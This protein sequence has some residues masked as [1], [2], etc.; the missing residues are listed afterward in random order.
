M[1]L[2][3][4]S[5]A[6]L[7]GSVMSA[8][9]AQQGHYNLR[10][11]ASVSPPAN[12]LCVNA[13]AIGTGPVVWSGTNVAA[14]TDGPATC[15]TTGTDVWYDWMAA[16]SG[17]TIASLCA[18][19]GGS[20]N[21]DTVMTIYN[22]A[23][24]SPLGSVVG[25]ND[26]SCGT[27]Q[28]EVTFCATAGDVY[29]IRIGGWNGATGNFSLSMVEV[30]PTTIDDCSLPGVAVT[31]TNPYDN[32]TATAQLCPAF[33]QSS[34]KCGTPIGR[35]LWYTW[36]AGCTSDV[37]V[38]TCGDTTV[39]TKIAVWAGANCP[40]GVAIAC[41]DDSCDGTLQSTLSF[42]A[43][44][45]AQYT[46]QIGSFGSAPGGPGDFTIACVLPDS[47][48]P[49]HD[50]DTENSVA[51]TGL[52][53]ETLWMHRQGV[54][55]R[56]T[57]VKSIS[58]AWGSALNTAA[59]NPTVGSP[60][61]V[62][63]WDDLDDDGNPTTNLGPTLQEISATVLTSGG[64][65]LDTYPLTPHVLVSGVYFIGASY[66][67]DTVASQFSAPLDGDQDSV[68]RAYIAGEVGGPLDFTSLSTATLPLAEIDSLGFPGVW[69][70]ECE[71][72][73]LDIEEICGTVLSSTNECPCNPLPP[74]TGLVGNGC[75]HSGNAGS[76]EGWQG[77]HLAGSGDAL[78]G[79]EDTVSVFA[80]NVRQG[81]GVISLFLQGDEVI[82]TI[83]SDGMICSRFNLKLWLWKDPV[84][85]GGG[86]T[87]QTGPGPNTIPPTTSISQ[88]S[89]D[90]GAPLLNGQT[91]VYTMIFRDPAP[92][93]GC[94][95]LSTVN[96]T[97][98]LRILW[99]QL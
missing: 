17:A 23:G 12:D 30:A 3:T 9:L 58:T 4:M 97:N 37:T 41:N 95:G 63:I 13:Q 19:N 2:I 5:A 92:P 81:N 6:V 40:A 67:Q 68:S 54:P 48:N 32:S 26:T 84:G 57:V 59:Q 75:P 91:K 14:N 94:L 96:T 7:I 31:G 99:S 52:G 93:Q 53:S 78:I 22:G 83:F 25:C 42:S 82:S 69:L 88:R 45:G 74:D 18:A 64:D 72:K 65:Q 90:L 47:C 55:G 28:S 89:S 79:G 33:G 8:A 77:A 20:G 87:S 21:F 29:K 49:Y 85:P 36:T 27:D 70:L 71:C 39:D 24:C 15:A 86:I 62:A 1:K 11:S 56:R 80:T 60:C 61:R 34:P 73:D 16:V 46:V 44:Q 98:G 10:I 35:D 66:A 76:Q 38:S 51:V 43:T 50:A